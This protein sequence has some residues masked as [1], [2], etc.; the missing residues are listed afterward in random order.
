MSAL[1]RWFKREEKMVL[2]YDKTSTPLTDE[3][4]N[5]GIDVHFGDSVNDIPQEVIENK[6]SCVVVYT[7]AIPDS[8]RGYNYLIEQG[9]EVMKRSGMLGRITE[10]KYTIA[11]AGTHGKT[12]T[13]SIIAHILQVAK[14]N[15]VGF[16]GGVLQGYES[17]LLV[18]GDPSDETKVVVEADEF[19]RSF[20]TLN[21]NEAIVTSLDADHLD[22]YGDHEQLK[23]SFAEFV[24]K[25]DEKGSVYLNSSVDSEIGINASA[26]LMTYGLASGE[27]RAMN[28]RILESR[29]LFDY[30]GPNVE[31][32]DICL[33]IPGFH[34]VE[35]CI[36][37]ISVA[38]N[39]QIEDE[40]IR[41]AIETYKGVKRRF[42]YVINESDLIYIDDYAH[43]PSE[44]DALLKSVKALYPDKKITA[45]FQPHLY[46][47]TRDFAKG[48]SESLSHA[49]EVILLNIYPARELPIE[50][51]N[52]QMLL[53]G[54]SS[55]SKKV[56][57]DNELISEIQSR[58]FEVL[59][60]IGAG[61]I[62]RFVTPIKNVL[63]ERREHV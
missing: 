13:S 63:K 42:E 58:Q 19:D 22:I 12:T 31:I 51:I 39:L 18:S 33:H 5:E 2:G 17:N 23:E 46:T 25:V 52:S 49:D 30:S 36:A 24:A 55:R 43:H 14:I 53:D 54:I 41:K 26:N 7:P 32:K 28:L 60:T 9:Y 4:Q 47:R 50:G 48:F 56:L 29:F 8:H 59:L 3:L 21:P 34:N 10:D 27:H 61:D 37:A 44:I 20:L 57:S 45:I 11:V 35:N 16:L 62:D 1:A 15:S 38:K 40:V 6:E